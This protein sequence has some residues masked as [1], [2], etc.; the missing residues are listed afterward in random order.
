M[1]STGTSVTT[2]FPKAIT[3]LLLGVNAVTVSLAALYYF[4]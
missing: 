1:K 3:W 2:F 4:L